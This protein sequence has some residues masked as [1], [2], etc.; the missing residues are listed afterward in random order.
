MN[1]DAEIRAYK[2]Q[3]PEGAQAVDEDLGAYGRA[4]QKEAFRMKLDNESLVVLTCRSGGNKHEAAS[5][6]LDSPQ[7]VY[8]RSLQCA[9]GGYTEMNVDQSGSDESRA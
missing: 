2:A 7:P 4:N 3:N 6:V 1:C 9:C 5:L 8:A